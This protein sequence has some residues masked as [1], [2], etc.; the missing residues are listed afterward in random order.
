[1][2]DHSLGAISITLYNDKPYD[3]IWVFQ[4]LAL[5][6]AMLTFGF[7]MP[8][9]VDEKNRLLTGAARVL[10]AER[11]GMKTIPIIRI[12]H[13]SAAEKRAFIIAD[14][15]LAEMSAWDPDILRSELEFFTNL[16][17]DFDFSVI[18][19]DTAEVDIILENTAN[20]ADDDV[21]HGRGGQPEGRLLSRR[22]VASR[23]P[24]HLLRGRFGHGLL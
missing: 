18:G 6:T 10:A 24:P 22:P 16:N 15:K 19:F 11:L 17:I 20:D 5:G 12:S 21:P 2:V 4:P 9:L 1:M 8:C 13:L 14:N 23:G 3:A 7:L